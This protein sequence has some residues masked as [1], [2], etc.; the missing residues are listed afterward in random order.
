MRKL[1][2]H[3]FRARRKSQVRPG[4]APCPR[5]CH[6]CEDPKIRSPSPN[7]YAGLRGDRHALPEASHTVGQSSW[8]SPSTP[9]CRTKMP[10]LIPLPRKQKREEKKEIEQLKWG[11]F[12]SVLSAGPR[13]DRHGKRNHV[14]KH[15][16][17][18]ARAVI[19]VSP[20]DY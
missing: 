3:A 5:A 12:I 6:G 8:A 15:W 17:G 19:R 18:Q 4:K 9:V 11:F 16:P 7:A 13:L 2:A 10:W 1:C 20:R 14:E